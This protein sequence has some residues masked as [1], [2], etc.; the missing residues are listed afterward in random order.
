MTSITRIYRSLL[1]SFFCDAD[2]FSYCAYFAS[3]CHR[4]N[5]VF[6]TVTCVLCV[7]WR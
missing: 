7:L 4:W 6:L 3:G 2:C 1:L 5:C